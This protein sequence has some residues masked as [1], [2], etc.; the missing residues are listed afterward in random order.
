MWKSEIDLLSRVHDPGAWG[1]R[2]D[3]G[4]GT[5]QRNFQAQFSVW[6]SVWVSEGHTHSVAQEVE[7]VPSPSFPPDLAL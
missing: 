6:I 1:V 7:V 2:L 5:M 3:H 4:W